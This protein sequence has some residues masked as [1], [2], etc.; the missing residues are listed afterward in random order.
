MK[1]NLFELRHSPY[2][3]NETFDTTRDL[4]PDHVTISVLLDLLTAGRYSIDS[5]KKEINE[6]SDPYLDLANPQ[7]LFDELCSI[8]SD[9]DY[10]VDKSSTMFTMLRN[11]VAAR[12]TNAL[13]GDQYQVEIKPTFVEL[14]KK[15]REMRR[16]EEDRIKFN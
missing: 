6:F 14:T 7:Q 5:L 16:N 13:A 10:C 1:L 4:M 9:G 15:E 12:L 3:V 11:V 2:S 8:L